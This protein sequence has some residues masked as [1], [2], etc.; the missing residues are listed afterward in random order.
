[1]ET[2]NHN[3]KENSTI[4]HSLGSSI[5][6]SDGNIGNT[7]ALVKRVV[8]ENLWRK[9]QIKTGDIVEY[10][11]SDFENFVTTRPLQGLGTD[12]ETVKMICKTDT[13]ALDMLDR[14]C[15]RGAGNE[16]GN[17]QYGTFDNIQG[18]K[19]ETAPT[20]TSR[21]AA[22]RR[23]RKDRQD[24]HEKVL[25]GEMSAHGAMVEAGFRKKPTPMDIIRREI[26]K[27]SREE[28][29]ELREIIS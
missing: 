3:L 20:G 11:E 1:M 19:T 6:N 13:V 7:I 25:S 4:V 23:L 17:N 27:L 10:Q 14:V 2:Q 29:E 16:S 21:A 12:M 5:K 8:S 18:S 15:K 9:F 24:L 26:K 28:M 22:L